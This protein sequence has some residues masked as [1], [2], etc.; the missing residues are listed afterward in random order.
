MPIDFGKIFSK[1]FTYALSVNKLLPY[2]IINVLMFG[3]FLV[4]FNLAIDIIPVII[5]SNGSLESL[6]YLASIGSTVS[7]I[8]I[9]IAGGFVFSFLKLFIDAAVTDNSKL[10]WSKKSKILSTSYGIAKKRYISM[11]GAVILTGLIVT[12]I[13]YIPLIGWILTIIASLALLFIIQSIIISGKNAVDSLKDSYKIFKSDKLNVFIF[14]LLLAVISGILGIVAIMPIIIAAIPII[15]PA[16]KLIASGD[17]FSSLIP[18]IKA[19]MLF[20]IIG[21]VLSSALRSYL[22]A[23]Q[24][25]ARTFFYL[26]S[27]KRK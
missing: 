13:S 15:L 18:I 4:I 14:W 23:F 26:S 6:E 10:Y 5:L 9:A 8:L 2:F 24:Q 25:S 1:A 19:N 27:K 11:L 20:V 16:S 3:M 21:G 22:E 7:F 17:S 12:F